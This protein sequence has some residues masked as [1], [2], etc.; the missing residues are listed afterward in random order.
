MTAQHSDE[1]TTI[2]A[3]ILELDRDAPAWIYRSGVIYSI[4]LDN[5]AVI[6]SPE[7]FEAVSLAEFQRRGRIGRIPA[8]LAPAGA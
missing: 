5:G 3:P 7:S 2:D 6:T 4:S 1:I 8:R